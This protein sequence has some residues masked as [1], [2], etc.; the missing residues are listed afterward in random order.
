MVFLFGVGLFTHFF[1]EIYRNRLEPG[2]LQGG[3][4]G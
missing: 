4:F 2:R 1:N 3:G